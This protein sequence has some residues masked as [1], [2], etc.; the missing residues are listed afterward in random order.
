M[1]EG[2][3]IP[4]TVARTYSRHTRDAVAVL[5]NLIRIARIERGLRVQELA[6]RLGVSRDLIQRIERGDP[7]CGIGIF[8]EAATVVGVPLFDDDRIEVA[9]QRRSQ[10]DKLRLLPK[11]VRTNAR[12]V[13]DDF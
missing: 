1:K 8:F 11:A 5:G 4:R 9:R 13:K 3:D 2:A 12:A 6:D 7:R 10:E